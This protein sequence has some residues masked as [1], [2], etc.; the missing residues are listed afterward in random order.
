M[1]KIEAIIQPAKLEEFKDALDKNN[2]KGVTI[3]Q[4][5]GCGVTKGWKEVYRGSE[6]YLN[7]L[8]KVTILTVVPDE[9]AD[10]IINLIIATCRTGEFGDGKIF[11]S[12]VQR[13]IRIRSREEGEKVL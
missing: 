1:K 2:I 11:V 9:K 5:M 7:V 10:D 12:D 13:A 8:P 6:V 3:S 4:V